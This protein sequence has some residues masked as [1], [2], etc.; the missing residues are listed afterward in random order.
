ML[1]FYHTQ[2]A[3]LKTARQQGRRASARFRTFRQLKFLFCPFTYSYIEPSRQGLTAKGDSPRTILVSTLVRGIAGF[4]PRRFVR[5]G[6]LCVRD[7]KKPLIE[8]FLFIRAEDQRLWLTLQGSFYPPTLS[9]RR[10][11]RSLG[12]PGAIR[13]LQYLPHL[14]RYV[15]S[16][17][18][19]R[20]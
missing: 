1:A 8:G 12:I 10:L 6:G 7:K 19:R 9:K 4:I 15:K 20:P 16:H 13:F 11:G 17:Q 3:E 14:G 5:P 2:E 18:A